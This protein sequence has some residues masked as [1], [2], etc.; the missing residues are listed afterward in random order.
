M[1]SGL[2]LWYHTTYIHHAEKQSCT[3][4]EPFSELTWSQEV[5]CTS[6]YWACPVQIKQ[7]KPHMKMKHG[8]MDIHTRKCIPS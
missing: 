4:L 7:L 3:T 5:K 2:S 1:A 8:P 6:V